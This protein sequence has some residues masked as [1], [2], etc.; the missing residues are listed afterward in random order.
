MHIYALSLLLLVPG[1]CG[2]CSQCHI[3]P[4]CLRIGARG[5]AKLCTVITW[6]GVDDN[7]L[8]FGAEGGV[9]EWT[10][11]IRNIG[12]RQSHHA[13]SA[14]LSLTVDRC[15]QI[16]LTGYQ[17]RQRRHQPSGAPGPQDM[18]FPEWV[19]ANVKVGVSNMQPGGV[20]ACIL[21]TLTC[22]A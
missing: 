6:V 9:F 8:P 15:K 10:E 13:T 3:I 5:S 19:E 11:S 17:A 7:S 21:T 12:E 20:T 2:A 22:K 14:L 18:Y 4:N 16:R 1:R